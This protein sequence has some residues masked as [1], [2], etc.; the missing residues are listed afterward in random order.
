MTIRTKPAS[1]TER[2]PIHFKWP[3]AQP[4]YEFNRETGTDFGALFISRNTRRLLDAESKVP[5]IIDNDEPGASDYYL[6]YGFPEF[7]TEQTD[8]GIHLATVSAKLTSNAAARQLGSCA[9]A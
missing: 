8:E 4:W 5:L 2:Q 6:V 7:A 9:S 3:E 1:R